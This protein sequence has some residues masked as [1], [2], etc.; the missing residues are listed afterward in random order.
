MQ[1][2]IGC[3]F[4]RSTIHSSI[5]YLKSLKSFQVINTLNIIPPRTTALFSRTTYPNNFILDSAQLWILRN[6]TVMCEVNEM[7]SCGDTQRTH[8]WTHTDSFLQILTEGN[9]F[10]PHFKVIHLIVIEM[11]HLKLNSEEESGVHPLVTINVC[12][13][14]HSSPSSSC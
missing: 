9:R 2:S 7:N 12:T 13:K 5:V 14:C 1:H 8:T 11:F 10:I 6:T 4:D 3:C